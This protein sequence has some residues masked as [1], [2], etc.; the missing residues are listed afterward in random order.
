MVLYLVLK[1]FSFLWK[2]Q[3]T[4]ER[5]Y[6]SDGPQCCLGGKITFAFL[7]ITSCIA[8]HRRWIFVCW[9][10]DRKDVARSLTK[11]ARSLFLVLQL[12]CKQR[13]LSGLTFNI[14]KVV[15]KLVSQIVGLYI[16]FSM[17]PRETSEASH[18]WFLFNDHANDLVNAKNHAS[19]AC[20]VPY[21]RQSC[22]IDN[23]FYFFVSISDSFSLPVGKA[24]QVVR[25]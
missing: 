13:F 11:N 7:C 14:Y 24:K 15:L 20:R 10:C 18:L 12:P 25:Q 21:N 19:S 2:S 9:T 3:R 8:R 16:F 17:P 6:F 4:E 23:Q 5:H 1:G 22:S